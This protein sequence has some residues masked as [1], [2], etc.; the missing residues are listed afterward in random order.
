MDM[1]PE[2]ATTGTLQL[3]NVHQRD[4]P[5]DLGIGRAN[6]E[7]NKTGAPAHLRDTTCPSG[8]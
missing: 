6:I 4:A 2:P 7:I 8:M 3:Y 1:R 5:P